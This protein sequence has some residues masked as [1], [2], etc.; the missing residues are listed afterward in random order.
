MLSL[1][2]HINSLC[3]RT[4][5][6]DWKKNIS[7]WVF[8]KKNDLQS[9]FFWGSA[10]SGIYLL[11]GKHNNP[12][13]FLIKTLLIQQPF[14]NI[15]DLFQ[16][17]RLERILETFFTKHLWATASEVYED[18]QLCFQCFFLRY[19]FICFKFSFDVLMTI[20]LFKIFFRY[21]EIHK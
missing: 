19:L 7:G 2:A 9:W 21:T 13:L 14:K 4:F 17:E 5:V 6:S 11:E 10:K 3:F 18:W 12:I 1:F 15:W 8:Q 16:L 20:W